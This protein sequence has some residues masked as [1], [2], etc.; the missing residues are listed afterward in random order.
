MISCIVSFVTLCDVDYLRQAVRQR[1][2]TEGLRPFSVR[3]GIPVGQLRSLVQGRAARY[4]TLA[5]IAS[6]M[7][8][9]LYIGPARR[10][11]AAGPGLSSDIQN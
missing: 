8:L 6:V 11:N 3:T 4:T 1:I 2:E 7:G 9:Q 5:S 10:G